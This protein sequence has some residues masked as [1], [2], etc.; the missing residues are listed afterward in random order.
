MLKWRTEALYKCFAIWTT[1]NWTVNTP[2]LSPTVAYEP[3]EAIQNIA[4]LIS[5]SIAWH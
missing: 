4:V 1:S 3:Y 2:Q 5:K